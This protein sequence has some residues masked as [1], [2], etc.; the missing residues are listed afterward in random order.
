MGIAITISGHLKLSPLYISYK[1]V[2]IFGAKCDLKFKIGEKLR[3]QSWGFSQPCQQTLD[4][5]E[6]S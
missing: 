3:V 4:L 1:T 2:A 6:N 5:G